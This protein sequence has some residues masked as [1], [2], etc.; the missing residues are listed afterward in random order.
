VEK[1]RYFLDGW[2]KQKGWYEQGQMGY[3]VFVGKKDGFFIRAYTAGDEDTILPL[4][5]KV[6]GVTRTMEHWHWKFRDNPYGSHRIAEAFSAEGALVAHYA[7]YPIPFFLSFDT[8]STF[9]SCQI[10]D[11]M[12]S[13][14][15]RNVGLGKT[16]LLARIAHYFYAKFGHGA[17]PFIYGFNTGNIRKLGT[18]YLGYEYIDPVT[19]WTRNLSESPMRRPSFLLRLLSGLSAEEVHS[20]N[21]E[22]DDLFRRVAPAYRL[23]V[24][25]DAEYIKWRYLDCPDRIHRVFAVRKWGRLA[26]WSVFAVRGDR[27]IW[28]DALFDKECPGAVSF[29]LHNLHESF[30]GIAAVEGWFSRHPAWWEAILKENGFAAGPEPNELTPGFV[31]FQ[32]GDTRHHLQDSLYYTHGDSDLF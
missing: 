30:P 2:K 18:R 32:N 8:S 13:P 16:G 21:A 20:T 23:L 17:M 25:R 31:I 3:E 11:T 9:L 1:L 4:F 6:F 15:V 28:G 5:N 19:Y 24:R 10:G 27:L 26:G 7:G 14:S 29:L 12:T 22:W